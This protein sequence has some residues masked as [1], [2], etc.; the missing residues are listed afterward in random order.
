MNPPVNGKIQRLFKALECF[1][2]TFDGKFNFQVLF[3]TVLIQ[4]CANPVAFAQ[5]D[6]NT[7]KF[8]DFDSDDKLN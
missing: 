1:S 5:V 7:S 8:Y 4:A 3:K 2:S 6:Y